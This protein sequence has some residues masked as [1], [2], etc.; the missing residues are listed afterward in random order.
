MLLA[1]GDKTKAG[2]M[3]I[4]AFQDV[5]KRALNLRS[6]L[7]DR[8]DQQMES[9]AKRF[10]LATRREMKTL[11]RQIRELENQVQGLDGQLTQERQRAE[12]AEASL[13]DTIRSAREAEAKARKIDQ[14]ARAELAAKAESDNEAPSAADAAKPE[15]D[16]SERATP[17]SKRTTR[18]K[19]KSDGDEAS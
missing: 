10:N 12:R 1:L 5:M 11:R 2:I 6:D 8:F 19:K 3:T 9:V 15:A 13:T 7:L 18:A 14:A 17:P 16:E 4:P